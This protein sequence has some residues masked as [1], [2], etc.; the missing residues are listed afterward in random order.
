MHHVGALEQ[1][2]QF[3]HKLRIHR[4]KSGSESNA[5][6]TRSMSWGFLCCVL[7][8]LVK[9]LQIV[10]IWPLATLQN[11]GI[12]GRDSTTEKKDIREDPDV[13]HLTKS[14]PYALTLFCFILDLRNSRALHDW[15]ILKPELTSFP[16][17][18]KLWR[19]V[20][21]QQRERC[22]VAAV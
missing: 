20:V 21:K 7:F 18:P 11:G 8:L 1:F 5:F 13:C 3:L 9:T 15:V 22:S 14:W 12:L 4:V 2:T 17:N 19:T 16:C 6:Y 10:E